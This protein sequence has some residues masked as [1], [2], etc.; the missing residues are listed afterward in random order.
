MSTYE[1]LARFAQTWGLVGFVA[2]FAVVLIY[3]LKPSNRERF[4]K[5]S[6]VP[7]ERD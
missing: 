3:A 4:E 5:A 2:L 7:L 1:I 6:R